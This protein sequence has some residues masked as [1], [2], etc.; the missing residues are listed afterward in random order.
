MPIKDY[1]SLRREHLAQYSLRLPDHLER[2]TWSEERLRA[3][4]ERR[5]QVLL[6]I[7]K[8]RSPWHRARLAHIDAARMREADLANIPPMTK[9][10]LMGNFDAILTVPDLSRD[11]VDAHLDGLSEDAYLGGQ[12]HVVA[13]GGSSGTR[14]VFVFDWEGWLECALTQQ[15]FR[16]RERARLGLGPG[17]VAA[18]IAGGKA[19]HMSYA[20]ARTFISQQMTAI[21]A[22]LAMGQVV[23]RLNAIQP[24]LLSGYPSI[25]FALASETRAGRLNIHPRLAMCASEP[26][27]PE[28][29]HRIEDVWSVKLINSYFTS[30]G[31]SACDCGAGHGMHLNEDVCIFEPVD[32]DG[33][34][35]AAGQRAAKMYVT[36]LFNHA[37]PLIRYELTD[38]VTLRDGICPCGSH[39]RRIDDI[40][41][42]SD[43]MFAYPSG[44]TVHPMAFRSPLGRE[45]SVVEYQV[46]QT[47][48]GAAITLRCEAEVDLEALRRAIQNELY[49]LGVPQPRVTIDVVKSF[50]R[51]GTGKLK[52]FFPLGDQITAS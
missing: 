27:L 7:A 39:M 20:M 35:I 8:E 19:S 31:A 49:A 4:R 50:D 25:L 38:E 43:D 1:D 40:G 42:R 17:T 47:E 37:Q 32:A 6:Q 14:G 15:R 13:S 30:E 3:E 12:Y 36:V 46:R 11:A 48:H 26:L 16:V 21:P 51:A 22:T 9:D 45:R 10:D 29:R 33:K 28:M 41:G 52:R 44:V 18:V 24:A 5:L 34:P 2:L 23:E